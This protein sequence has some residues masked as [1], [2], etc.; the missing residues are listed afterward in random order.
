MRKEQACLQGMAA[1]EREGATLRSREVRTC[2]LR[3]CTAA[4]RGVLSSDTLFSTTRTLELR[5]EGT[6]ERELVYTCT[7]PPAHQPA[8][9]LRRTA[10]GAPAQGEGFRR[11]EVLMGERSNDSHT[12]V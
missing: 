6:N 11:M 7:A 12:R 9:L 4:S 10:L 8:L 2:S 5:A 3:V 1:Y